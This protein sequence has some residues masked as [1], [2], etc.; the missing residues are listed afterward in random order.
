MKKFT[1]L[2]TH[3]FRFDSLPGLR[4]KTPALGIS[5]ILLSLRSL[6]SSIL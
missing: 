3:K 6:T 4:Y 5:G 1:A 2:A